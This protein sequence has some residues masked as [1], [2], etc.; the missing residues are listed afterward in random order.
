MQLPILQTHMSAVDVEA[1]TQPY[2]AQDET[3]GNVPQKPPNRP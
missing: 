1:P 3:R 2:D